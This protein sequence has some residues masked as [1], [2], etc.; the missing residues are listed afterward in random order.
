MVSTVPSSAFSIG[1]KGLPVTSI[2]VTLGEALTALG[3][4][5]NYGVGDVFG[6]RLSLKLTDG[7]EFSAASASGSLQCSYFASPFLYN[8]AILCTPKPGD[9]VVDMQDSY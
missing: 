7:R 5:S 8:S 9:Y 6:I 1:D 3:L 4:G 2:S